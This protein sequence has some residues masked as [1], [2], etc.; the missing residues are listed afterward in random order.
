MAKEQQKTTSSGEAKL[1]EDLAF[2][3]LKNKV[4]NDALQIEPGKAYLI[5]VKT[6]TLS[7]MERNV[8]LSLWQR[9]MGTGCLIF[10]VDDPQT[11]VCAM[12]I[13]R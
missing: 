1:R 11:Y 7:K 3:G 9:N 12:E 8:F 5:L 2:V 10:E 13:N 4:I 6:G